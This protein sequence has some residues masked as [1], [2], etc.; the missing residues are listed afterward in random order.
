MK[1]LWECFF[2]FP[3]YFPFLFHYLFSFVPILLYYSLENNNNKQSW[4]FF[5][6]S[7][8]HVNWCVLFV[9]PFNMVSKREVQVLCSSLRIVIFSP[10]KINYHLL[11]LSIF[12]AHKPT[13]EVKLI[14]LVEPFKYFKPTS[15]S[16]IELNLLSTIRLSFWVNWW[17]NINILEEEN[18][19]KLKLSSIDI[20]IML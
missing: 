19:I 17:F 16:D 11:S 13:S 6:Y 8:F 3:K 15:V 10:I 18:N 20:Y 9:S 12:Q 2:L 1:R 5:R 7:S 4:F 14:P